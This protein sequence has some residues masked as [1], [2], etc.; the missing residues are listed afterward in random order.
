MTRP[1]KVYAWQGHRPGA[2]PDTPWN[3]CTTE[4]CAAPTVAAVL[5][6]TGNTRRSQLFNLGTTGNENDIAVAMAEPGVVFWRGIDDRNGEW[7]RVPPTPD[8]SDT[9]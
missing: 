2:H 8:A 5:R 9:P 6:A 7:K 1:L 3:N 4:V